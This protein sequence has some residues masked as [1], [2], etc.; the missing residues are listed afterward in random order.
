MITKVTLTQEQQAEVERLTGQR[1]S[2]LELKPSISLVLTDEQQQQIRDK[3]GQELT[4]LELTEFDL[5]KL[6]APVAYENGLT[7][8][9]GQNK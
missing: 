7:V 5:K 9:F 8:G 6:A 1:V 3:T 4:T 2:H